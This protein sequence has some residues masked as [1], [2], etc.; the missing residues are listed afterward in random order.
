MKDE[1]MK[2]GGEGA[3]GEGAEGKEGTADSHAAVE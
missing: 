1:R 2:E 3:K